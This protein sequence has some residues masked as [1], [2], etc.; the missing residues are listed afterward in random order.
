MLRQFWKALKNTDRV[1]EIL[2][3]RAEIPQWAR[4]TAAYL[5]ISRLKYP[6]VLQLRS[7]ECI[8]MKELTDLKTFWQVFLRRVYRVKA[9]DR[10]ILDLGANIGI[11]TLY[12]AR[13]A[14]QAGILSLE[15]FPATFDRLVATVRDH[16]LENRVT[17]V[18]QALTGSPGTRV[19]HDAML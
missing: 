19:M 1:P 12:A 14:P 6:Y 8:R 16:K 2:R 4:V 13:Q 3:C 15:P 5:G 9:T 7:G 17:C 11:F 18:K 10:V